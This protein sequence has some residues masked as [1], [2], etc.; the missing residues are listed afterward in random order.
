MSFSGYETLPDYPRGT[1]GAPEPQGAIERSY[2]AKVRIFASLATDGPAGAYDY[3]VA[4]LAA[5]GDTYVFGT[6][7]DTAAYLVSIDPQRVPKSVSPWQWIVTLRWKT[8]SADDQKEDEEGE[9][10][11][12]TDDPTRWKPEVKTGSVKV[13]E[14]VEDAT[15]IDGYGTVTEGLLED[16]GD[17]PVVNSAMQP[18]DPPATRRRSLTTYTFV[19]YTNA[20]LADLQLRDTV[21][22]DLVQFSAR[23]EEFSFPAYTA[24]LDDITYETVVVNERE[25]WRRSVILIID[26]E[27]TFR[28]EYLDRGM[29]A[30][31]KDGDPNGSGG[32]YSAVDR[33]SGA[34]EFRP[35]TD[36][37][38]DEPIT[39]PVPFDG[40][41]QPITGASASQASVYGKWRTM[42]ETSWAELQ[43][44]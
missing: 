42:R 41:G 18:F 33:P 34:I 11:E 13:E 3:I 6:D 17:G 37:E 24:Y 15:Y 36:T 26:E 19:T 7:F 16:R 5:L 10:G 38:T 29:H 27:K 4:N 30:R 43:L 39:S 14:A 9:D 8:K 22:D 32:T 28:P 1:F 40:E 35:I 31:A 21:N 44:P 2:E 12:K 20:I 23:D 25:Y